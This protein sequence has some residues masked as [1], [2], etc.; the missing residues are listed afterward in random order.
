MFIVQ[1]NLVELLL[2]RVAQSKST[3][4]I[5]SAA[6]YY[7][8]KPKCQTAETWKIVHHQSSAEKNV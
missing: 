2:N 6:P 1:K 4:T 8:E 5:D 3:E 7:G